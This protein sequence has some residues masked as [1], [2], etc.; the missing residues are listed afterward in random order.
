[1]VDAGASQRSV[2]QQEATAKS[3][4]R[5]GRFSDQRGSGLLL[6]CRLVSRTHAASRRRNSLLRR[7]FVQRAFGSAA[8]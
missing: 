3:L 7:H 1:M 4:H 5:R 8:V 2:G 6:S